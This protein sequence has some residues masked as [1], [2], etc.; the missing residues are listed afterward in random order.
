MLSSYLWLFQCCGN[1]QMKRPSHNIFEINW[2]GCNYFAQPHCIPKA[3]KSSPAEI[4]CTTG[5]KWLR[6]EVEW[7]DK[8]RAL[9]GSD[10]KHWKRRRKEK[11]EEQKEGAGLFL[12]DGIVFYRYTGD[13]KLT[14][15]SRPAHSS[16]GLQELF[17]RSFLTTWLSDWGNCIASS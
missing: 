10:L 14:S 2:K 12:W 4:H 9:K 5:F 8:D 17:L 16:N 15:L 7:E 6:R 1:N 13:P 3:I 11:T